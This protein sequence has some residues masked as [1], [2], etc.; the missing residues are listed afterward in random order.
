ME[1][2]MTE[3]EASEAAQKQIHYELFLKDVLRYY[4]AADN[5]EDIQ[6]TPPSFINQSYD[7]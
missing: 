3:R 7:L 4:A 5:P 1:Q 2:E 6:L